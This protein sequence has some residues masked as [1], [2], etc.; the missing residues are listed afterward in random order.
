LFAFL[1]IYLIT[2]PWYSALFF[3]LPKYGVVKKYYQFAVIIDDIL[4]SVCCFIYL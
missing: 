2:W 3:F 4:L 1:T